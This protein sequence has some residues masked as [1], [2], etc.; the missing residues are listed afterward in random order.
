MRYCNL[1]CIWHGQLLHK[2]LPCC[3]AIC[4]APGKD[5]YSR[6]VC[7]AVLQSALHL[8]RI[9]TPKEPAMLCCSLLCIWHR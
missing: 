5:S 6:G 2:S 8:A 7:H 1:L 4:S 3:A 9:A